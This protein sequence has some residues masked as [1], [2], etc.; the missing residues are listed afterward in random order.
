MTWYTFVASCEIS[1]QRALC[2][3]RVTWSYIKWAYRRHQE[4]TRCSNAQPVSL[5][6]SVIVWPS[7]WTNPY[8]QGVFQLLQCTDMWKD[9]PQRSYKENLGRNWPG[10]TSCASCTV[11]KMTPAP[12]A[13]AHLC[14]TAEGNWGGARLHWPLAQGPLRRGRVPPRES[15]DAP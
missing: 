3:Q 6:R 8:F 11:V 10:S 1:A 12:R 9:T 14:G 4:S 2:R 7:L 5:P 15:G 13:K